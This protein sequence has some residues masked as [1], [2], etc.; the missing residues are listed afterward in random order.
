MKDEINAIVERALA[1]N[2]SIRVWWAAHDKRIY[3]AQSNRA[4]VNDAGVLLSYYLEVIET[5][6]QNGPPKNYEIVN[7]PLLILFGSIA[8]VEPAKTPPGMEPDQTKTE[9]K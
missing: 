4:T 7:H 8:A 5:G 9:E 3:C 6:N 1:D 2:Q